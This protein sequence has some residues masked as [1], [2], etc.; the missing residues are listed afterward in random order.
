MEI[1]GFENYIIYRDGSIK[2]KARRGTP[3]RVLKACDN[4]KG[5]LM[6]RM[7]DCDGR[8]HTKYPHRL[9][10]EHYIPN[11]DNKREVDHIDRNPHNND[12]TNLRWVTPS[13]NSQNKGV[14]KNNKLGVKNIQKMRN[15][16]RV[17]KMIDGKNY[18]K[19]FK[20]LEEAIVYREDIQER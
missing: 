12:I 6:V 9:V 16:Y 3:E 7:T 20:T 11:P 10:A 18:Y 2:S 5:Y 4:G 8:R 13:E 19:S 15:V 17:R 14:S 1:E